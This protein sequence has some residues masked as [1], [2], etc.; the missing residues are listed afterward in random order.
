MWNQRKKSNTQEGL[1]PAAFGEGFSLPGT[2]DAMMDLSHGRCALSLYS[3]GKQ[4]EAMDNWA[5]Q[6]STTPL[7]RMY[8]KLLEYGNKEAVPTL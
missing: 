6:G 8:R 5:D 7:T 2:Q 4:A 1:S 3:D